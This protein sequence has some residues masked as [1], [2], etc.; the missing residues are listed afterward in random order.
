MKM[1]QKTDQ[2]RVAW[3]LSNDE[4]VLLY[5]ML[6]LRFIFYLHSICHQLRPRRYVGQIIGC[7]NDVVGIN[8]ETS[9]LVFVFFHI[10]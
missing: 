5:E 8:Q 3:S 10:Y 9:F 4:R 7:G 6:V 2:C 1:I